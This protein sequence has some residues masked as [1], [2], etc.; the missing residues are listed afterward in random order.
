MDREIPWVPISLWMKGTSGFMSIPYIILHP[1]QEAPPKRC[2][3]LNE[4]HGLLNWRVV[5]SC[6]DTMRYSSF[7]PSDKHLSQILHDVAW[8]CPG[9]QNF[10]RCRRKVGRCISYKNGLPRSFLG[11]DCKTSTKVIFLQDTPRCFNFLRIDIQCWWWGHRCANKNRRT[12]GHHR[13]SAATRNKTP[14]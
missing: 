3:H 4:V 6:R 13:Y 11:F 7:Q 1:W 2:K 5:S 8:G 9:K 12:L 10:G 14:F